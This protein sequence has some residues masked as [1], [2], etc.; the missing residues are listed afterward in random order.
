MHDTETRAILRATALLLFVCLVRWASPPSGRAPATPD[1]ADVLAELTESTRI[2][3]AESE[4]RDRPL[5]DGETIDVNRAGPVELDRLP[6]IGPATAAAIAAARD[7]GLVFQRADDLLQ[8]RGVGP[9]LVERLR[10]LVEVAERGPAGTHRRSPRARRE[11]PHGGVDRVIDVNR[12]GIDELQRLPGVGPVLAARIIAARPYVS[13]QDLGRVK[14][15]GPA[16]LERLRTRVS[17][18]RAP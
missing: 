12:A 1:G 9:A 11:G 5:A 8:V 16:T 2:A 10:D 6:G 17:V 7:S 18:G 14:G 13:V 4:A 15:V 3:A